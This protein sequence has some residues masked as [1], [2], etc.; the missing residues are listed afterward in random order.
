MARDGFASW[1]GSRCGVH[2]KWVERTVQVGQ[3]QGTVGIWAGDER[4][5][6]HLMAQQLGQRYTLPGQWEGLP[7]GDSRPRREAMAVQI[8]IGEVERRSLDVY[9]LAAVGGAR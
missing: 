8:P 6:V 7:K 4:I 2:W 3:R 5:A 1:E 9:E